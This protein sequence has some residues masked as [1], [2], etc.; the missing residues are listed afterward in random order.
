M[1]KLCLASMTTKLLFLA[2]VKSRVNQNLKTGTAWK[3][4]Q[5]VTER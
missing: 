4:D 3:K 2:C 5:R 1:A